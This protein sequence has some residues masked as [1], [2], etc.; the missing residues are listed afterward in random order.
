MVT[1]FD[2][3]VEMMVMAVVNETTGEHTTAVC[4]W[5]VLYHM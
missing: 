2:G 3:M 1:G 4:A 5:I